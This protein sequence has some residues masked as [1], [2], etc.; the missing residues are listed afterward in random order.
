MS[1]E[2]VAR[3]FVP[4]PAFQQL[5]HDSHSVLLGP[6]GCGKTTLL[7]MLNRRALLSWDKLDRAKRFPKWSFTRPRFE[8]IYI[9]SDVRWSYELACLSETAELAPIVSSQAQRI[10]VA[11]NAVCSILE[12]V[13]DILE[14][15]PSVEVEIADRLISRWRLINTLRS[16]SDV[17]SSLVTL[18]GEIRGFLN[19]ANVA[20]LAVTFDRVPASFYGHVLDAPIELLSVLSDHMP[21]VARPACWALCYDELEIAPSWLR[22]ELLEALRSTNQYILLKLTWTPLLPS[23]L[24]T[25]P[26]TAADFKTIRLWHSHVVDPRA[27]CEELTSDFLRE[28]F[29]GLKLT[30]DDFFSR[31]MLGA[32]ADEEPERSYERGSTEYQVFRKLAQWDRSFRRLLEDRTIDP[33]DPVPRSA[34]EKDQFYRK[35]KPIAVLRLEF[36]S[37][38]RERSRKAPTIYAGKEAI[39]S[40]SEGNPRWL[41]GLLNDLADLSGLAQD[42]SR[43][44]RRIRYKDQARILNSAG[45]RFLAL[46][47]ASP[48]RPPPSNASPDSHEVTLAG[49]IDQV[50]KYFADQIY[51]IEFPMD[52]IGSFEVPLDADQT[53]VAVIE[54][55]LDL[56]GVVYIG[57]STQDVPIS[58]RGSRFR[59]AFVLSPIHRLALRT[60]RSIN[61][62][63]ILGQSGEKHQ[64]TLPL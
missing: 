38:F 4:V 41:R 29:P 32:E 15:H 2:D 33:E 43:V 25:S 24:R 27:F 53:T 12:T 46:I 6:R 9:S 37:E 10:M 51:K 47:K 28:R 3:S 16:L 59:L 52:P 34:E 11:V 21:K 30:P 8:A 58:V 19:T 48:F 54:Q 57:T 55:L 56:G 44:A 1:V 49:F 5:V 45:Q 22:K 35:I 63:Q 26:E 36:S 61:I 23:G 40:M 20:K 39:Y 42:L 60:Y 13:H 7:K 17:K 31:S 50:G 18:V 64:L 14:H 62:N